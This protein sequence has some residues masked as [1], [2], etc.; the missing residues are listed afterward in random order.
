MISKDASVKRAM[1]MKELEQLYGFYH[2]FL[3][4]YPFACTPG[5]STCCTKN[6][7]ATSLEMEFILSDPGAKTAL[8][9]ALKGM[10]PDSFGHYRPN[11]TINESA[12]YYL[13]MEEPPSEGGEGQAPATSNPC[14]LLSPKGLCTIYERRPFSCRAMVS[15]ARCREEGE[16]EMEPFILTVNLAIQQIIEHLDQGG[17]YGNMWDLAAWMVDGTDRAHL[18]ENQPLPGFLITPM[19]RGRFMAFL[20]R[21]SRETGIE[22]PFFNTSP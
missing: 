1:R 11:I 4:G 7:L 20:R 9:A 21:L 15:S 3:K 8:V 19:E 10:D 2:T 18:R 13:R 16:A 6:V 12:Q 17:L 5:C 14:P 22:F